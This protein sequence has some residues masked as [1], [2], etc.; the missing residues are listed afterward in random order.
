MEENS[1]GKAIFDF[2]L[3]TAF[4]VVENVSK[5][6]FEEGF[7]VDI[8]QE[9]EETTPKKEEKSQRKTVETSK[10][11]PRKNFTGNKE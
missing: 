10:K 4:R 7:G 11:H 1:N 3:V 2:S 5:R 8:A 6:Y 9:K